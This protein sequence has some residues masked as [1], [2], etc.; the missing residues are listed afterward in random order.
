MIVPGSSDSRLAMKRAAAAAHAAALE[1]A[2]RDLE[3]AIGDAR[4]AR[5]AGTGIPAADAAWREAKALLIELETGAPPEWARQDASED[6]DVT[7]TDDE[8]S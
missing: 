5:R 4:A 2:R 6:H 8:P 1:A 3:K 7:G